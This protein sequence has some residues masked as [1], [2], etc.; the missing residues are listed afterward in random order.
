[1][2]G[3]HVVGASRSGDGSPQWGSGAKPRQGVWRTMSPLAGTKCEISIQFL[4]FSSKKLR[5]MEQSLDCIFCKH[6]KNSED[7]MKGV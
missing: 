6:T 1:M 5:F 4:T 7:S 3:V 2:E